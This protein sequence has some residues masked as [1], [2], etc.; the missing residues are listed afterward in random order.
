[1]NPKIHFPDTKVYT[2]Q[3]NDA[4][5]AITKTLAPTDRV[6]IFLDHIMPDEAGDV[7]VKEMA[8]RGN[9]CFVAATAN[10]TPHHM[11]LFRDSGYDGVLHKPYRL[12]TVKMV[13]GRFWMKPHRWWA[14]S[15]T[16]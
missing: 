9:L 16:M 15:D 2:G 11:Q 1:M 13:L 8:G 12:Y 3:S 5:K 7:L 10:I 14:S 6:L 4:A